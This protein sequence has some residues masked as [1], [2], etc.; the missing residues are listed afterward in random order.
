M[1]GRF[2]FALPDWSECLQGLLH[3]LSLSASV[4]DILPPVGVQAR[5]TRMDANTAT[6][7]PSL[8]D[9]VQS[10]PALICTRLERTESPGV[11]SA[12]RIAGWMFGIANQPSH[13]DE[14]QERIEQL[15]QYSKV[16]E[17]ENASAA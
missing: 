14:F 13:T 10:H 11:G 12:D 8:L 6:G 1:A 3:S 5:E 15:E 16:R 4:G 17:M 2:V 7:L 9:V